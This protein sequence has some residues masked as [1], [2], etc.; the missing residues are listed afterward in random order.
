MP[1]KA[2]KK[3]WDEKYKTVYSVKS[4]PHYKRRL[5][6][7]LKDLAQVIDCILP[8]KKVLI[9][10]GGPTT[11]LPDILS[12]KNCKID[13]ADIS[14]IG[15]HATN[16]SGYSTICCDFNQ[17][18]PFKDA[19]YDIVVCID[20]LEY[21]DNQVQFLREMKRVSKMYAIVRVRNFYYIGFR[22]SILRGK[23]LYGLQ[24]I[25]LPDK[26]RK[27]INLYDLH[28]IKELV[29]IAEL[30]IIDIIFKGS[31]SALL[32]FFRLQNHYPS[33]FATSIIVKI[34]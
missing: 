25:T 20:T 7:Y 8:N 33:I 9:L 32:H 23:K 4:S 17:K 19:S 21:I 3:R 34:A 26:T 10:G 12:E 2:E 14:W 24:F 31:D 29:D 22:W 1:T 27:F 5:Q 15:L 6:F 11:Y 18:L 16:D 30:K 13:V 28:Y